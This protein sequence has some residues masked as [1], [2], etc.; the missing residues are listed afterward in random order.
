MNKEVSSVELEAAFSQ[1][2]KSI[3]ENDVVILIIDNL[4]RVSSKKVKEIWSD[5]EILTSI[6]TKNLRIIVPYSENHIASAL[7]SEKSKSNN[8]TQEIVQS[9]KSGQEFISKRIPVVFRAPPIMSAGWREPFAQYW[10]ETLLDRGGKDD[11]ADLIDLWSSTLESRQITPRFLK[12]HINDIASIII[13]NQETN[14]KACCC[15]AYLL[16]CK[17]NKFP[18]NEFL[19]DT[20]SHA[21]EHKDSPKIEATKRV[22]RKVVG[23]NEWPLA[24]MAIHYQ[25][26]TELA[27]CELLGEPIKRAIKNH[28]AQSIVELANM[29]GFTIEFNKAIRSPNTEPYDLVCLAHSTIEHPKNS[30]GENPEKWVSTWIPE[31][32]HALIENKHNTS[33]DNYDLKTIS[34]F[35]ALL[36]NGLPLNLERIEHEIKVVEQEILAT[37]PEMS[38]ELYQ[39]TE[40]LYNYTHLTDNIPSFVATPS[41]SYFI[42]VL[43]PH[44][45]ELTRWNITDYKQSYLEIEK[46]LELIASTKSYSGRFNYFEYLANISKINNHS[47]KVLVNSTPVATYDQVFNSEESLSW[48]ALPFTVAW[49]QSAQSATIF[50]QCIS[51]F[52]LNTEKDRIGVWIS[53]LL[54]YSIENEITSTHVRLSNS[55]VITP[56]DFINQKVKEFGKLDEDVLFNLLA[57]SSSFE[58]ILKACQDAMLFPLLKNTVKRLWNVH[59]V[60]SLQL[61]SALNSSYPLLAS[62]IEDK[63]ALLNRLKDWLH[64]C[65]VQVKNWSHQLVNDVLIT[66]NKYFIDFSWKEISSIDDAPSLTRIL[67][68]KECH[69]SQFIINQFSDGKNKLANSKFVANI[70]IDLLDSP[71]L[72]QKSGSVALELLNLLYSHDKKRVIR[73]IKVQLTSNSIERSQKYTLIEYFGSQVK[74]DPLSKEDTQTQVINLIDG[75]NSPKVANWINVQLTDLKGWSPDKLIELKEA[76]EVY[77]KEYNLEKIISAYDEEMSQKA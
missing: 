76:T 44:R 37:D 61:S 36:D 69:E 6:C 1:F 53:V 19:S 28:D 66:E 62:I 41:S 74:L 63:E 20:S 68:S 26:S 45:H 25:T 39:T 8:E 60:K 14:P 17:L 55:S 5:L 57:L 72:K 18:V 33:L 46:S 22:L 23:I 30:E 42:N 73:Q 35:K 77:S 58:S 52:A 3:P 47:I 54:A 38:E 15:S 34:A 10:K 29:Y 40:A 56:N 12:K 43:W 50:N 48:Y 11:V 31:V 64:S 65:D 59:K 70:L 9:S 51:K 4:D 13:S 75:L 16:V 21:T 71:T 24:I 7:S 2:V 32:N 49:Y 27:Q 67:N